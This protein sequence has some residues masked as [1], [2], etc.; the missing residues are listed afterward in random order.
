M[1]DLNEPLV[2]PPG[3]RSSEPDDFTLLFAAHEQRVSDAAAMSPPVEPAIPK[4]PLAEPGVFTQF[5]E[6]PIASEH[7]DVEAVEARPSAATPPPQPAPFRDAGDFTR[8]FGS[9]DPPAG[10]VPGPP[11]SP[12]TA[13]ESYTAIFAAKLPPPLPT[14]KHTATHP[15]Q[16]AAPG[17]YTQIFGQPLPVPEAKPS[18]PTRPVAAAAQQFER[19]GRR[20]YLPILLGCLGGL[21]VIL[22]LI[23]LLR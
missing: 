10:G 2:P 22:L 15:A 3:A 8:L 11:P 13:G 14:A 6:S 4:K 5:F 18:P 16:E 9:A 23:F 20:R 19:R 17:E 12:V 21:V 1:F 7:M